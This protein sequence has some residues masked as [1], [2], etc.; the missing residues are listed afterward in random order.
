MVLCRAPNKALQMD[1]GKLS[2]LLQKPRQLP[3]PL[4]LVVRQQD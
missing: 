2:R 1:K 4:S 3:L